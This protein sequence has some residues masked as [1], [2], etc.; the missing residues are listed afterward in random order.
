MSPG[1]SKSVLEIA[2]KKPRIP[3]QRTRKELLE[4]V[5]PKE[6][7]E[8]RALFSW[9]EF[10]LT[11]KPEIA[12][13]YAIPNAGGYTGGFKKNR[14]RVMAMKKEGVRAGVPDVCLP[15]PRHGFHSLYLELKRTVGGKLS[16]DQEW[17]I[18]YLQHHGHK[19]VVC[20]G[21]EEAIAIV[22]AYLR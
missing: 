4:L 12:L 5:A 18:R 15:V 20:N 13:M 6:K 17:W 11:S 9:A 3:R 14:S 21:A 2:T 19:V 10:Q 8:Q 1:R 7:Y 16:K 22:E